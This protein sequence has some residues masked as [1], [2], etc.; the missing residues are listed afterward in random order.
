M[1]GFCIID[2]EACEEASRMEI[3]RRYYA[4]LVRQR[5]GDDDGHEAT[6]IEMIMKQAGISVSERKVIQAALER[7][8]ETG[9]PA[10]AIEL[11]NGKILSGKTTDLL[12]S[13]SAAL[14]NALKELADIPDPVLLMHSGIIKPVQKL[15]DS[16]AA[17]T[18]GL[19]HI[20][21][22]LIALCICA[23]NDR[24]AAAALAELGNVRGS[25]LH[26]TVI[27]SSV[28]LNTLKELGINVTCEPKFETQKLY[29][30]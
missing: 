16:I 1:A 27:L 21:E 17:S 15:K 20:D 25:E 9:R 8:E 26:S 7:E 3:I 29:N 10:C 11:P 30:T 19:L 12:G 18:S 22:I 5:K 2:N 14:L 13:A 24:N 4:A 28:D 23:I 6:K